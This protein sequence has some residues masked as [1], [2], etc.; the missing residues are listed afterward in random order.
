MLHARRI[1]NIRVTTGIAS[2]AIIT[3]FLAFVEDVD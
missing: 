2:Q 3:T 1:F